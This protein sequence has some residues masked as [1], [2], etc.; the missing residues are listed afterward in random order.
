MTTVEPIVLA[1]IQH[2][3]TRRHTSGLDA[4]DWVYGSTPCPNRRL[5]W[6][7]PVG[8]VSLWAGAAGCGKSRLAIAVA[9][10]MSL[11][12]FNILFAQNEVSP[13]QLK[14]WFAGQNYDPAN[15]HV[16]DAPDLDSLLDTTWASDYSLIIIDSVS[17]L[18]GIERQAQARRII[19]E[20]KNA[21][22]A[23][24]AHVILIGHLNSRGKVKGGTTLPHLVDI[25]A[26]L[27]R[28]EFDG[29]VRF[30]IYEKHRFG[31]TGRSLTLNHELDGLRVVFGSDDQFP[32]AQIRFDPMTGAAIRRVPSPRISDQE[33]DVDEAGL[34]IQPPRRPSLL[35]RL[36]AG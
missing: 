36:L 23:L 17:M 15:I 32:I 8:G 24:G 6:G 22:E 20:L 14:G 5:N 28:G 12:G 10:R 3:P 31:P 13:S 21:A 4:L 29:W 19:T 2:N 18:H 34:P 1:D 33:I 16:L 7:L 26:T 11:D 25:M 27:E 35:R 30:G 9:A